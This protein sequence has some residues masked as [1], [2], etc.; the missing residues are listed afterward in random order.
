MVQKKNKTQ[1]T[2]FATVNADGSDKRRLIFINESRT[3]VAFRQAKV[4]PANLPV[5]YQDNKKVWMLSGLWY[6][7]LCNLEADMKAQ[8]QQIVLLTDNAPTHP[9]PETPP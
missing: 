8:G 3:P 5:T 4:N 1:V 6:E 2:V 7:Y 9:H